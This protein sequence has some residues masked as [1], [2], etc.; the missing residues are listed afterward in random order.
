MLLDPSAI[1]VITYVLLLAILPLGLGFLSRLL[2]GK[3][4]ATVHPTWITLAQGMTALGWCAAFVLGKTGLLSYEAG[5]LLGA[6]LFVPGQ[7]FWGF[8]VPKTA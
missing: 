4:L 6:V 3:P 7:F 1:A 8:F 5:V 2:L